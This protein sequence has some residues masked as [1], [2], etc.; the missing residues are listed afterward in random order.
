MKLTEIQKD[1]LQRLYYDDSIDDID[2]WVHKNT[3]NALHK[4]GLVTYF[5]YANCTV[6]EITD[7]GLNELGK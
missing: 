2:T 1:T 3:I 4:K 7:K 5:N 6:W